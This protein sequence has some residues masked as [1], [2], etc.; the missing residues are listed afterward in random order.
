MKKSPS[1]SKTSIMEEPSSQNK[2]DIWVAIIVITLIFF[3]LP[4]IISQDIPAISTVLGYTEQN[5]CVNPYLYKIMAGNA[6]ILSFSSLLISLLL[7]KG[8]SRWIAFTLYEAAILLSTL[9]GA[10]VQNSLCDSRSWNL[11]L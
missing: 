3:I 5:F 1:K 7:T 6:V 4:W 11:F 8:R 2:A 10:L 9:L